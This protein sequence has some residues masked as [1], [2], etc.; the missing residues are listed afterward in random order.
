MSQHKQQQV[1]SDDD[2]KVRLSWRGDGEMLCVSY[3][4]PEE[5]DPASQQ[6]RRH[7]ERQRSPSE[8]ETI[9]GDYIT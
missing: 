6:T 2:R 4:T 8:K 5:A 9:G 7:G 1:S 3:V